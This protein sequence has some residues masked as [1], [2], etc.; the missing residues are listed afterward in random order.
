MIAMVNQTTPRLRVQPLVA[1][2]VTIVSREDALL[3]SRL[4]ILEHPPRWNLQR[5]FRFPKM[6]FVNSNSEN[7][8]NRRRVTANP[9]N[10]QHC[11]VNQ[12]IC[13]TCK[14]IESISLTLSDRPNNCFAK[15][16]RTVGYQLA[17][18]ELLATQKHRDKTRQQR[19]FAFW[20]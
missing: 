4:N 10:N 8:F 9:E 13:M 17:I 15:A 3:D 11:S 12:V 14:F 18:R 1:P 2:S 7:R 6:P 5:T 19:L 20:K 16:T